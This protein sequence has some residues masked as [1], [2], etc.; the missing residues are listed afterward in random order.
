MMC[1]S[2]RLTLVA[3]GLLAFSASARTGLAAPVTYF[4]RDPN[5]FAFPNAHAKFNQF[6]STLNSF[7][8]DDIETDAGVNPTLTFGATGIT[9]AT[10]GVVVQA[11]PGIG[12]AIDDQALLELEAAGAGQVDTTFT[13]NQY[14]T[15]FGIFVIEGGDSAINNNPT[16]F[17]L[18]D[19]ATNA[20][21]DVPLQIGPN[22]GFANVFF[23]GITDTVP[24]DEVQII[25]SIDVNDGMLYDNVVAGF[26]PE[27]G[28]LV[29]MLLCGACVAGR[30]IRYRRR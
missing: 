26:V 18:R 15:A 17:R 2:L 24:F 3:A 12:I 25:E 6:A 11:D 9:A 19:T 29:L 7:G 8:V 4:D 28:S 22:W 1:N 10:Q 21:V 5:T 14:V 16:T 23:L 20:S 30:A 13:F 27:P